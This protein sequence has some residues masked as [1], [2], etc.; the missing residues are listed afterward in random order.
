MRDVGVTGGRW[1]GERAGVGGDTP[2]LTAQQR[3]A[4]A[5]EGAFV[6]LKSL[7]Q[8]PSE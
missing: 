6:F 3:F 7:P 4:K 2:P 1:R 5:S 8:R